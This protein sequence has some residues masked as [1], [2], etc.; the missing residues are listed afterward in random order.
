MREVIIT[1]EDLLESEKELLERQNRILERA[2]RLTAET[3]AAAWGGD[4]SADSVI[5]RYM[6]LAEEQEAGQ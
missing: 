5:D 2:L 4:V 3:L 1:R 6:T